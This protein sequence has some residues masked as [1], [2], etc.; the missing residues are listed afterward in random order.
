MNSVING[1]ETTENN[2]NRSATLKQSLLNLGCFIALLFGIFSG[3]QSR[4]ATVTS[5]GDGDYVVVHTAAETRWLNANM[6]W[7]K[8]QG[9]LNDAVSWCFSKVPNG[10]VA[11]KAYNAFNSV[12]YTRVRWFIYNAAAWNGCAIF[13]VDGGAWWRDDKLNAAQGPNGTIPW[14]STGRYTTVKTK[15]KTPAYMNFYGYP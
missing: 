2:A 5:I 15:F 6:E 14:A 10:G 4:A 1:S 8:K 12:E 9:K 3:T 7:F 13:I 11:L